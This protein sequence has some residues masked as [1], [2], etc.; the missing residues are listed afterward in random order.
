MIVGIARRPKSDVSA[1]QWVNMYSY[2]EP[3]SF[4]YQ[5][6]PKPDEDHYLKGNRCQKDN[7]FELYE[8]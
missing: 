2:L 1:L 4:N 8:N 5:G 3:I 7:C 6:K